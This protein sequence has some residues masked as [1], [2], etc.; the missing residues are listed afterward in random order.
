VFTGGIAQANLFGS[1]NS[2]ST[3]M[4]TSRIN[5]NVSVS[6]TNPYFTDDGVSRGFDVYDRN[7]NSRSTVV[8]Q[9]TSATQG[10]GVRFGVPIGEDESMS[11]GISVEKS[12]IGLTPLSPARFVNYV[13]TF[14][15]VNTTVLGTIGWGRD[16][17]DSAIYTTAGM[18]QHI[19]LES[20]L[21]I[22]DMRYYKLNYDHQYYH[23]VSDDWVLLLNGQAGVGGGYGGKQMPFFKNFY[24]G[25]TGSVRGF[26]PNS[27]GPR[28][29]SNLS[30]GGTRRVIGNA[31]LFVPFPGSKEKSVRLSAFLDAGA[32]YGP[33]D[34]PGSMGLR[35]STGVAFTWL[36]PMGPLKFSYGM[37]LNR[38][39][40]DRIQK[41]QFTLGSM[42]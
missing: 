3:Q 37:A 1:G 33:T 26:D 20:A 10:G 14:G 34:L 35:Y 18:V 28:D 17:R 12:N 30:I 39:P 27:L 38:Q 13:N 25:G 5:R 24:A 42:F 9:Y 2:L 21:P 4:N 15:S 41:L 40:V 8:S 29:T 19:Y 36:S 31:E 16:T 32:V 7:T 22:L 11:Y 23:P 6:Y